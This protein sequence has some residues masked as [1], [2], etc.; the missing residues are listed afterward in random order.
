LSAENRRVGRKIKKH[1]GQARAGAN[2]TAKKV[3]YPDS[4][5]AKGAGRPDAR[6]VGEKSEG[7]A[8]E[9]GV[10]EKKRSAHRT[11]KDVRF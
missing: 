4:G 8:G 5:T 3:L 7:E 1:A 10:R 6:P 9:T 11:E 2:K